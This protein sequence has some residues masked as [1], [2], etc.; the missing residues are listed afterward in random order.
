MP[1]VDARSVESI[2]RAHGHV[3]L[4]RARRILGSE[5]DARDV[6]QEIFAS[7]IDKGP[8]FRGES[9]IT[10][11]LYSAT[12]NACLNRLRNEKTRSKALDGQA[13][14]EHGA[15]VAIA[16]NAES[17]VIVRAVRKGFKVVGVPIHLDEADGRATSHYRPIVDSLRIAGAVT[18]ARFESVS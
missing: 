8:S 18:R 10:T 13:Q 6:L 14:R 9:S 3:V 4:R 16:S 7:I 17:A 2:Y 5:D 12:T 15:E 11:W 1:H